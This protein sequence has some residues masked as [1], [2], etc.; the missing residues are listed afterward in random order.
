VFQDSFGSLD[1]RWSVR[2]SVRE[3]LDALGIGTPPER[4]GRVDVLLA[5][6]GLGPEIADRRPGTLSGGQRQRVGI[7]A[8]LAPQPRLLVADEPVSALDVSVQAQILNL[9]ER[10][11]RELGLAL[12]LITHNIGVVE[13]LADDLAVMQRGRIEEQGLAAE[14]LAAPA[15]PYTRTLLDAVPR[16]VVG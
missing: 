7:A 12:V 8:A 10:L 14:V 13:F 11:Q 3:A 5:E 15:S 2:R 9:L 1:P 6:V 4:D 16:L